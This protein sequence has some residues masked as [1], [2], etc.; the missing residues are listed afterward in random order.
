[1]KWSFVQR[2]KVCSQKC[3]FCLQK[4]P[5]HLE[6]ISPHP[7]KWMWSRLLQTT[8]DFC[9]RFRTSQNFTLETVCIRLF[10]FDCWIFLFLPYQTL[11][12]PQDSHAQPFSVSLDSRKK[13]EFTLTARPATF[14]LQERARRTHNR[15][16][17]YLLGQQRLSAI[18]PVGQIRA[19]EI[20]LHHR[21]QPKSFCWI[22]GKKVKGF[23]SFVVCSRWGW[24]L[25][26]RTQSS[27]AAE[28]PPFFFESLQN[29]SVFLS[30][31]SYNSCFPL[32]LSAFCERDEEIERKVCLPCRS[33]SWW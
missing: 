30:W 25:G 4:M 10:S 32:H 21:W 15:D 33:L 12:L 8:K 19:Q 7:W 16:V 24:P 31:F 2:N 26:N 29:S 11:D 3:H 5:L 27:M 13:R 6:M 9:F 23:N 1:M 22:W 18:W 20:C 28:W 17:Q 14:Y